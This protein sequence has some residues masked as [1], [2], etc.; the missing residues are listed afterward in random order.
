MR[1]GVEGTEMYWNGKTTHDTHDRVSSQGV[2]WRSGG[3]AC[4]SIVLYRSLQTS[5]TLCRLHNLVTQPPR[6]FLDVLPIHLPPPT[7]LLY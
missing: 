7:K 6:P 1:K 2:L 3:R 5:S 4:T